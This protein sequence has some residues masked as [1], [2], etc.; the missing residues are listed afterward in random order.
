[1]I[2]VLLTQVFQN[3]LMSKRSVVVKIFE[4][5]LNSLPIDGPVNEILYRPKL[6]FLKDTCK[7]ICEL[8]LHVFHIW[9]K[10]S[11]T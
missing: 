11:Y 5:L 6:L 7:F 10:S 1:M 8:L 4:L 3:E 2:K 9:I